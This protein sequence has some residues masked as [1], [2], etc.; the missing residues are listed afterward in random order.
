MEIFIGVCI[1][2]TIVIVGSIVLI[3]HMTNKCKR[4]TEE[5]TATVTMIWSERERIRVNGDYQYRN[6]R[7]VKSEW[8]IDGTKYEDIKH[9]E[10]HEV[11]DTYTLYYNKDNH[12]ETMQKGDL[13]T[14]L[15][16]GRLCIILS[17]I[18]IVIAAIVLIFN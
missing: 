4:C 12:A 13:R 3:K 14:A 9:S 16:L 2:A 5:T 8:E 6:V 17:L 1:L 11:G 18:A 15:I 10:F 7:H